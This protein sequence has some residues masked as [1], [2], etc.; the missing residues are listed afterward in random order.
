MKIPCAFI[1]HIVL[2]RV[3]ASREIHG[4]DD[5]LAGVQTAELL[6]DMSIDQTIVFCCGY[7]SANADDAS[8]EHYVA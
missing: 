8:C 6:S 5:D 2:D 7:V 4:L 1:P 3:G